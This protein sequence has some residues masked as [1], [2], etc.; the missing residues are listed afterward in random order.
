[1]NEKIQEIA[2][3]K[4]N[5][6]IIGVSQSMRHIREV[7]RH[8]GNYRWPVLISGERGTGKILIAK[9]IHQISK[10]ANR[11]LLY[12]DCASTSENYLQIELFGEEKCGIDVEI[13]NG[14]L[15]SANGRTVLLENVDCLPISI[16]KDL[17]HVMQDE[18]YFRCG[19]KDA[20]DVDARFISTSEQNIEDM[21]KANLFREDFF[22]RLDVISIQVPPLRHRVED[23][24]PL[25]NEFVIRMQKN[26]N[27]FLK[28]VQKH[29]L[30]A[31]FEKYSWPGNV[32]ELFRVTQTLIINSDWSSINRLFEN[33]LSDTS[34]DN[35]KN[36]L[37]SISS[38]FISYCSQDKRFAKK[39]SADLERFHVKVWIDEGE[40]KIGDSLIEKIREGI[41]QVDYLAVVITPASTNSE[42][43]K[44]E[45]E[46]AMNQEIAGK[47]V[48]VLPLL[49]KS[50]EMPGFLIGKR[51][52]DFSRRNKYMEALSELLQR[53]G[54]GEEKIKQFH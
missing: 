3:P 47:K 13:K 19:G 22:Y 44:R 54:V 1:V 28:D 53:L 25:L 38:V 20:Y 39:L 40:I 43:V 7:V 12:F 21:I 9:S 42:W 15:D 49:L 34:K 33:Y 51:Y 18:K 48:K 29:N 5:N 11:G 35:S 50:C 46:I 23:I 32:K 41:D 17:L 16:Q 31:Q 30:L 24:E 14:L 2:M 52:A 6:A 8:I 36:M 27:T 4:E 10:Q 26:P 37:P 45:V